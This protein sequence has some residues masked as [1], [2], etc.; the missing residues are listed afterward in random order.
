MEILSRLPAYNEISEKWKSSEKDSA[1]AR[2][3]TEEQ[4]S[5][6]EEIIKN[7]EGWEFLLEIFYRGRSEDAW[8]A[9]DWP[10]GFD[11]LL[12]C[13]PLCSL[14]N[15][16]CSRCHVGMRQDNNSCANDFSLFG[17]TVEL[18]KNNDREGLLKHTGNI[19]E[20]LQNENVY[21]NIKDRN[22]EI[23]NVAL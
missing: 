3:L 12:L 14:V 5:A 15:F 7:D 10:D 11:E 6:F 1:S 4:V 16:D 21:W 18:L 9:L 23:K 17:Y 8:L 22:T 2:R 13:V 20:V 19:K